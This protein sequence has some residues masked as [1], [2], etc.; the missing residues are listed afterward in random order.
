MVCLNL[1]TIYLQHP[2]CRGSIQNGLC[3]RG[4]RWGHL[5]WPDDL[6]WCNRRQ[7]FW[8]MLWIYVWIDVANLGK[9]FVTVFRHPWGTAAEV[10]RRSHPPG[11]GEADTSRLL[12]SRSKTRKAAIKTLNENTKNITCQV[13]LRQ[14]YK[15][16]A[17]LSDYGFQRSNDQQRQD[18]TETCLTTIRE[19]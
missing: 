9:S 17:M 8:T 3:R 12:S 6:T 16:N 7:V 10:F 2:L 19:R 18:Q 11:E 5:A 4:V 13:K 15:C 14:K 1:C